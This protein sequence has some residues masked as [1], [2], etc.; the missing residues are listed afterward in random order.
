MAKKIDRESKEIVLQEE[1]KEI[2]IE[3]VDNP[4][5][6]EEGYSPQKFSYKLENGKRI[7]DEAIIKAL[8]VTGGNMAQAAKLLEINRSTIYERKKE[9]PKI[10]ELI[11]ELKEINIDY[12]D[13]KL[14]QHIKDGNLGAIIFYL[15]TMGKHRGYTSQLEIV[16]SKEKPV[17]INFNM[18]DA[19]EQDEEDDD[20][21]YD[22]VLDDLG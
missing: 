18:I 12:A 13:Y 14:K 1:S 20:L 6:E 11:E 10:E 8:Q 9:V 16:G 19:T 4:F 15:K 7:P 5:Y 17:N 3:G 2:V 21:G 22:I